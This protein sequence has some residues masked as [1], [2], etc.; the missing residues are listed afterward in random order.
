[1]Y[2]PSILILHEIDIKTKIIDKNGNKKYIPF[3]TQK[4]FI[5]R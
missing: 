2:F 5:D 4:S 3:G 1:M